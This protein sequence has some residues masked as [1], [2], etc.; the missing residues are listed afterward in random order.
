[1]AANDARDLSPLLTTSLHFSVEWSQTEIAELL[2]K[3][4]AAVD[5]RD[6]VGD[7]PLMHALRDCQIHLPM[8]QLLLAAGADADAENRG[9][10]VIDY[11]EVSEA[12][13]T[14]ALEILWK[15]PRPNSIKAKKK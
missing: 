12:T 5:G 15:A 8:V 3:L 2:L 11:A 1:M 9:Y 7:T 13:R 6:E 4:G 10:R 14:A